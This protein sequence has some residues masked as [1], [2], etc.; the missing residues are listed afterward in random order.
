MSFG[1]AFASA[2][3]GL[4]AAS[5]ASELVS[6]N[7]ANATTPGYGR[8]ALILAAQITGGNGQGVKIVS[9]NRAEDRPLLSDRRLAQ[10]AQGDAQTRLDFL[11]QLQTLMGTP[12]QATSLNGCAAAF[13]AAL[14]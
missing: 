11:T 2:L 7:I 13:H 14:T 6:S 8:R 9:V 12:D 4:T 5:K 1:T 10:S 3:S